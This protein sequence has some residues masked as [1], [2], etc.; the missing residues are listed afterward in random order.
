MAAFRIQM[1]DIENLYTEYQAQ[2]VIHPNGSLEVKPWGK[3]EF[4]IID[5]DGVCITFFESI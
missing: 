3:K 2:N 1:E 4:S 5:L